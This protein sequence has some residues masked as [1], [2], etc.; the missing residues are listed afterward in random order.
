MSLYDAV[1]LI[2]VAIV[3]AAY[4]AATVGRLSPKGAPSLVLNFVG[5]SLILLSLIRTFNLAA[6]LVEGA[7]ALI[8]LAGLARMALGRVRRR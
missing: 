6:A 1:G 8:A 7:W 4:A 2:G 3:L 5:A